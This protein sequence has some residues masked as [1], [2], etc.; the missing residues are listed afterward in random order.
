MVYSSQ[1]I[2]KTSKLYS[3]AKALSSLVLPEYYKPFEKKYCT[4]MLLLEPQSMFYELEVI[5]VCNLIFHGINTFKLVSYTLMIHLFVLKA[6]LFF[7]V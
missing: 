6:V 3:L 5:T 1:L 4:P 2:S 7:K